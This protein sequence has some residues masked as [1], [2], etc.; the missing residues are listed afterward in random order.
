[1]FNGDTRGV[2]VFTYEGL[3]TRR[4]SAFRHTFWYRG[5]KMNVGMSKI[6]ADG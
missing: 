2:L 6:L 4:A 5:T 3:Y 1:M